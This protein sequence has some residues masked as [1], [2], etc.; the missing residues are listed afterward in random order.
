MSHTTLSRV[1]EQITP[2]RVREIVLDLDRQQASPFGSMVTL[3]SIANVLI[4]D[5]DL[6]QGQAREQ[7]Q[8]QVRLAIRNAVEQIL[9]IK[10][11]H[12]SP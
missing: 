10:Y 8:E 11:V 1:L 5:A 6:G 4:G 9:D 3:T 7:A 12:G 2:E